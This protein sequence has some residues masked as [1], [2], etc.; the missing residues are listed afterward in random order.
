MLTNYFKVAFRLIAKHKAYFLINVLSLTLGICA[1][2]VIYIV[3]SF[4]F[5]FDSFHPVLNIGWN[6]WKEVYLL[7]FAPIQ[8]CNESL[9]GRTGQSS[10]LF[11]KDLETIRDFF[12]LY[13]T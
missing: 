4:E 2:T 7:K 1:C 9:V 13:G 6:N 3:A 10:N 11:I 8:M 12:Q 5:S